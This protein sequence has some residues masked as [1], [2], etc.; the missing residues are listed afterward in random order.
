MCCLAVRDFS[1][2]IVFV[3]LPYLCKYL[4]LVLKGRY[5][6]STGDAL[7]FES[8]A[9]LRP[10]RIIWVADIFHFDSGI[11]EEKT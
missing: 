4:A 11:L 6:P 5:L 7:L 8:L 1:F 2:W 9:L 10:R 3:R